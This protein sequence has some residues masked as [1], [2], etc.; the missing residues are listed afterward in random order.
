M[1]QHLLELE[2]LSEDHGACSGV[3]T[4]SLV[5]VGAVNEQ[6]ALV[7]PLP[8]ALQLVNRRKGARFVLDLAFTCAFPAQTSEFALQIL[9][10]KSST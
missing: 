3:I 1:Y 10:S 4:H 7:Q 9:D 6:S 8:S 5:L 2:A